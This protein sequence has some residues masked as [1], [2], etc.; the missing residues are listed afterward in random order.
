MRPFKNWHFTQNH[1]NDENTVI[2]NLLYL[3]DDDDDDVYLGYY[4]NDSRLF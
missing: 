4:L 1:V 3:H 2:H